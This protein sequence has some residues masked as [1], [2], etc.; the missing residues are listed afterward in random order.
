MS[1]KGLKRKKVVTLIY[2]IIFFG[3]SDFASSGI[4]SSPINPDNRGSTVFARIHVHI[5][6]PQL[7]DSFANKY[8]DDIAFPDIVILP[9]WI[10]CFFL[11]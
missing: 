8:K 11:L 1:R 4:P 9:F 10:R 2:S 3:Y 5:S 7:S 6:I